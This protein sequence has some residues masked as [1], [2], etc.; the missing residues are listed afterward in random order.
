M[1]EL[2]E[3]MNF[4]TVPLS[5]VHAKPWNPKSR[6]DWLEEFESIKQG[7]EKHGMLYPLIVRELGNEQYELVDGEQ[8]HAIY[9][10]LGVQS[11]LVNN[12]G[13]ISE[14]EAKAIAVV[15]E[16]RVP[17][18]FTKTSQLY[19]DIVDQTGIDKALE[20]LTQDRD[21]ILQRI[22]SLELPVFRDD[23]DPDVPIATTDE[24]SKDLGK[25]VKYHIRM[26][27]DILADI[28]GAC[29]IE[30]GCIQWIDIQAYAQR[31]AEQDRP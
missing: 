10:E 4:I 22:S 2:K 7:L 14:A 13:A 26:S 27:S 5:A 1:A 12:L 8:R 24:E 23:I 15:I 3:R 20:L 21:T 29:P 28:I 9:T 17:L 16:N 31:H 19:A 25:Q 30:N 6:E 18:D 11:V